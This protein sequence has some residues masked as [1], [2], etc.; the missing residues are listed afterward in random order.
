METD[1]ILIILVF[2]YYTYYVLKNVLDVKGNINNYC[3][4]I[5]NLY[6]R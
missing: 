3:C 5:A 1:L 4:S 2:M 6:S